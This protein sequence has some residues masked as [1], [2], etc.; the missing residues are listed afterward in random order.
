MNPPV[1]NNANAD[2]Q[3]I[4]GIAL[5]SQKRSQLELSAFADAL[6]VPLRSVTTRRHTLDTCCDPAG[7]PRIQVGIR[8]RGRVD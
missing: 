4:F 2:S 1:L 5:S 7:E 3:P 8:C 6:R